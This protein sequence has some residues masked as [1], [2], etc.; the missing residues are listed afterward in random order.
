[1]IAEAIEGAADEDASR[2]GTLPGTDRSASFRRVAPLLVGLGLTAGAAIGWFLKP[3]P[4]APPLTR[5]LIAATV[6]GEEANEPAISPEGRRVAYIQS[7]RLH[8]RDLD[9]IQPRLFEGSDDAHAPFWSPDGEWLAFHADGKL[10]KVGAAGGTPAT[11][12]DLEGMRE[13]S[14]Q[15]DGTIVFDRGRKL[16]R[17]SARG[18]DPELIRELPGEVG[19]DLHGVDG[20]PGSRAWVVVA[21][22][23]DG[24]NA[25]EV[26]TES[27]EQKKLLEYADA[28]LFSPRYAEPGFVLF[29][30][31]DGNDGI[32]ALP[33][34][35]SR[36]EATGDPF[37][38]M[39]D[40]DH[41]SVSDEGT[42]V[43]V[44]G[45]STSGQELVWVG[46][47]GSIGEAVGK[48]QESISR[49][50]LSP[51]GS[52]VVVTGEDD[53]KWD[54][55]IHDIAR[56]TR[57]RLTF[58]DEDEFSPVW[59][60]DGT[61]IYFSHENGK[62]TIRRVAA[63]GSTDPEEIIEGGYQSLSGDGAWMAFERDGDETGLD[64]WKWS[65]R[66]GGEPEVFLA[67]AA[68]EE[69]VHLSPD[70][71]W[72]VYQSNESGRSE[73]YVRPFPSGSGKWQVSVDGGSGQKWG[74]EG[75]RIFFVTRNKLFRVDVEFENGLRLSS[76]EL[77]V[78]G[79]EDDLLLWRGLSFL[80]GSDRFLAIRRVQPEDDAEELPDGIRVVQN[81]LA[82][83]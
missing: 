36:L 1:M 68:D 33:F 44:Q 7:D 63:D 60:P 12:C 51:D 13:A 48:P 56:S 59:S 15:A 16:Q 54:L 61:L 26:W 42:L 55:W 80:P 11:I 37:L 30:R 10:W 64:L 81:W 25:V 6:E 73:V 72:V 24:S 2:D 8:V 83:F 52:K 57:M 40:G 19:R 43:A 41:P 53:G 28:T 29:E 70:G 27:G 69:N 3:P 78:D 32:W 18:G 20:L 67:T 45:S 34:S 4:P 76:P 21:H 71:K 47:D 58:G 31:S 9:R 62:D 74:P 22:Y 79:S 66:E 38:V 46:F 82:E 14:W 17:I 5:F 35:A 65:V 49:P 77:V 75:D 50:E 23:D 39:P